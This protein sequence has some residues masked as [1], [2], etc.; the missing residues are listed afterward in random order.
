ML[1]ICYLHRIVA[2]NGPGMKKGE[3]P[4]KRPSKHKVIVD[5]QLVQPLGEVALVDQPA[6]FVD[7][8]QG[9]DDPESQSVSFLLGKLGSEGHTL[10]L[11]ASWAQLY[12]LC[13]EFKR[14]VVR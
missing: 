12:V 13:L 10:C 7:D 1:R 9:I 14:F 4:M 6:G 11:L 3:V 2:E 5:I 8:Y